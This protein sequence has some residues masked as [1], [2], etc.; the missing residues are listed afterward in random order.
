MKLTAKLLSTA[1]ATLLACGSTFAQDEV[2]GERDVNQQSLIEA[3]TPAAKPAD[4]AASAA[5]GEQPMRMRSFRPAVRPAAAAAAGTAATSAA[6][7][8]TTDAL[9][10][11]VMPASD[12]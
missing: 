8:S 11:S 2:I 12:A 9:R 1:L 7:I 10:T 3:L 4:A 5:E 6:V